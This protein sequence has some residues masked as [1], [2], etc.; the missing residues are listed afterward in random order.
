MAGEVMVGTL[1]R[2]LNGDDDSVA[3]SWDTVAVPI[4]VDVDRLIA[5]LVIAFNAIP[6][7]RTA[8]SCQGHPH[9]EFNKRA[10][11]GL[12][13]VGM[14]EE[15]NAF[16]NH[17][18]DTLAPFGNGCEVSDAPYPRTLWL[19]PHLI[20]PIAAFLTKAFAEA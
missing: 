1:S 12:D 5:P 15:S 19:E 11:V 16:L 14:D 17:L 6:K 18:R 10:Y 8:F 4:L 20:E 13:Y 3:H 2:P 7:V 9:S